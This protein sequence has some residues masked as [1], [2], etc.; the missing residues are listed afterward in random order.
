MCAHSVLAGCLS[1]VY[2]SVSPSLTVSL[3]PPLLSL[4]LTKFEKKQDTPNV[5]ANIPQG[6]DIV[7][8]PLSALF[9]SFSL[10]LSL[11]LSQ[12][13]L[14]K[15]GTKSI[16]PNVPISLVTGDSPAQNKNDGPF[17]FVLKNS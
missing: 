9:L 3:S 14:H 5:I 15:K 8:V 16:P 6:T 12:S 1:L 13:Q 10:S 7:I 17:F 11:S 4:S 2:F